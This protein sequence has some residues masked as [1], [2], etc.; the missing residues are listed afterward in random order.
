MKVKAILSALLLLVLSS[1][2]SEA[3]TLMTCHSCHGISCQRTV[4]PTQEQECVDSLDYCVTIY[5]KS[6]VLYMGCSLEIPVELRQRCDSPNNGSCFKCNSNRCNDVG[7]ERFACVQCDSSKDTNCAENA[8]LLKP[9]VC[10]A[11]KAAN[12]YCYVKASGS[13]S[14]HI[15]RGCATTVIDQQDCLKDANCLLCSSG[16]IRGCNSVNIVTDSS[17]GNRFIR[18]L[19]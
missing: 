9:V 7:S 10:A 3:N 16:D 13:G 11:P 17:A 1:G 14:S 5:E 15:E 12:S 2:C 4:S 6:K 8:T 18:F 19:R